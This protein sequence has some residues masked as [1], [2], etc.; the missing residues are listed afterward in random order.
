MAGQQFGYDFD[1]IGNR[2]STLVNAR[3]GECTSNVN[4]YTQ[5]TVPGAVDMAGHERLVISGK[6]P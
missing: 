2:E 1:D 4:Q 5:R 3:T 6:S